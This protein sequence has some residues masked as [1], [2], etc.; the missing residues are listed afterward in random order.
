[1][2]LAVFKLEDGCEIA[3]SPKEVLLYKTEEENPRT[4]L[5]RINKHEGTVWEWALKH[6]LE[7]AVEIVNLALNGYTKEEYEKVKKER[8]EIFD[9]MKRLVERGLVKD[10]E[11]N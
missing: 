4:L 2:K 6:T 8:E 5:S 3:L 10:Q 1:M 7:E 11:E 9:E